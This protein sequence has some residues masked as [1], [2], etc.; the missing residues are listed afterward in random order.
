MTDREIHRLARRVA[1]RLATRVAKEILSELRSDGTLSGAEVPSR[2]RKE[3]AWR[4][5]EKDREYSDRTRTEADGESSWLTRK[6][7]ELIMRARQRGR[8]SR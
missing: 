1:D 4:D 5:N 8:R 3:D 2:D 7:D 6:A